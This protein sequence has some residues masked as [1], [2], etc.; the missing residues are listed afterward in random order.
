M[1]VC[2]SSLYFLQRNKITS[3]ILNTRLHCLDVPEEAT[4]AV[5]ITNTK[6]YS[7]LS[8]RDVIAPHVEASKARFLRQALFEQ[9]RKMSILPSISP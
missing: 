9:R 2:N 4:A 8:T 7:H 5:R 3:S 1:A 6:Q